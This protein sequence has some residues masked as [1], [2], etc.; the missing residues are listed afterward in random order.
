[1]KKSR[2]ELDMTEPKFE[3]LN[4]SGKPPEEMIAAGRK[5]YLDMKKRRSVRDFTD[6][7]VPK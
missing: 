2:Y 3:R 5:F 7:L 6:R 4:F 1:M